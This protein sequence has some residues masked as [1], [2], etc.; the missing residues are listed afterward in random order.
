VSKHL[1]LSLAVALALLAAVVGYWLTARYVGEGSRDASG[2]AAA[3]ATSPGA[4]VISD[5]TLRHSPGGRTAWQVK[6]DKI[7][8]RSGGGSV[9]AQGVRE[10]LI[11]DKSGK[12]MVRLTA[13]RVTGNT[14]SRDLEVTGKVRA[15]S[16]EGAVFDTGIIKWVQDEQKLVCPGPVTMR[17]KDTVIRANSC[18]FYVAQNLVKSAA[19]V[20]MSVANNT[21]IGRGLTYDVKSDDFSLQRVQGI[22]NPETVR[23]TL[24]R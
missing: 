12:P 10:A 24:G 23:E 11:Y 4:A 7:E 15:V 18:D 1:R 3:P 2:Q 22:F 14:R 6:L 17:N 9:A 21:L 16:P 13:D 19:K 20:Q 5:S 8:L